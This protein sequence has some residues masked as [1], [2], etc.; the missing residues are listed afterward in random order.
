MFLIPESLL[1]SQQIYNEQVSYA[2]KKVIILRQN[3][4]NVEVV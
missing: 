3:E 2:T 1:E 4:R